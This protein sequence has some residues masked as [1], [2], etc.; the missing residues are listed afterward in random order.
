MS[1]F[2]IVSGASNC[3]FR[4][5]LNTGKSLLTSSICPSH[6]LIS[7][8]SIQLSKIQNHRLLRKSNIIITDDFTLPATTSQSST[9]VFLRA[10]D[11][12]AQD[13]LSHIS[14]HT[15]KHDIVYGDSE[16]GRASRFDEPSKVRRPQWSPERLRSHNYVGDLLVASQSVVAAAGG[17]STLATLHEHDRSLRL[18]DACST[19]LRIAEVLYHST[20]ERM[21]PT[22]SLE[23]VQ[24][25]CVRSGIDATC[26]IDQGIQSV[27]ISR[28]LRSQPKI[29]VIVPTRGTTETIKGKQVVLAAHTI[30]T[31][32]ANS[33]YQNFDVIAVLDS[34]TPSEGRQ[35][36]ITAGGNRLEIVDYDRPFNFAEKIN[37]GAVCSDSEL[38][39]LLNDDTEIISPDAL[40]T[41]ASI[42]ED[43]S[44]AMA[45][46]M[47]LY[48]DFAIQSAGHILNPV[49]ID[50]YR[51]HSSTLSGA[52]NILKVQRETSGIIAACVLVKRK[53]FEQL[54]G[55]C[56][57]FPSNFNDVDFGLKMQD[58]GY[59][60][61]WTPHAQF[62]H[63]ESKTRSIKMHPSEVS[64]IGSRWRDKL[65]D[66]PYFNPHLERYINIWKENVMGQRSVLDALGPTAPIASK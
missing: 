13:A 15:A 8:S 24:Q 32:I 34:D 52:Q 21:T 57:L 53:V 62:H 39:L 48:E 65:E 17:I 50:L 5:L 36:I 22:A 6:W 27:R 46:P 51:G 7:G 56:T 49:P 3:S 14:T 42:L 26:S 30:E 44:V 61:V 40:E 11:M 58:A 19:P 1:N 38:L 4:D 31:L 20:Q 9:I 12:L 43:P 16:H 29:S 64:N 63:F 37:L 28:R 2:I 59:R 33:T 10:G 47:L 66:D 23:A 25:H 41:L 18:F 45:G 54:G 35:A 60:I 55:L